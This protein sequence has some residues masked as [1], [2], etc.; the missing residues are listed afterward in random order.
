MSYVLGID[1]AQGR[2]H[3]AT[4]RRTR[5]GWGEAEPLWLG[6]RTPAAASAL[7]L[8]DEGYLLTGDAAAQAGARVPARL[9]T[10][11]HRRIGD[12]VPMLV[13][14][15]AFPPETLTTVLVEGIAE[16]A[17]NLFGGA[18]RHLV[19][20][21]P[22][23]WGA[24]R[25][26]VLRRALADAGFTAVTL[27][28]GSVA[29]L[30]AHLPVPGPGAQAA[31][32]CEF[33]ADG[34][35]VTLATAGASGWQPAASAEGVA[36]A[37][38]LSTLFALAGAASTS[39]KGLAGVVFCGDV[40]PH[41]LPARPPCPV[42]A[43]PVP[44]ATAALGAAALAALRVENRGAP[45]EPPAVETTLLPQVDTLGDLGERPPRPP[46]EITPFELPERTGPLNLFRRRRPLAAAV[47]VLAAAVSAV[48]ITLTAREATAGPG[49]SPAPSHCAGPGAPS[50]E[51]HC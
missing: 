16:H 1:V 29:A 6:E 46:V 45:H 51:G 4:C 30:G 31:G 28:P 39:P 25:R 24:Y 15:E 22:G 13:E 5:D 21:H 33:G 37:A 3:A 43:G 36:P 40:P 2:T 41:A 19:L 49:P 17:A 32:V 23:D 27:V 47:L 38:A 26:D 42:F 12:D 11:F 18:P 9:L 10:G 48:V 14:G 7:F 20:T 34:V 35:H 44:P 50:G 8:D